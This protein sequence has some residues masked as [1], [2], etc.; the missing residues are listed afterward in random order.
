MQCPICHI[1]GSTQL[2]LNK[3]G[4][5]RYA[6]VKHYSHLDRDSKKP[7]FTYCKITDL[8]ALKTLLSQQNI[9]LKTEAEAPRSNGQQGRFESHDPQLRSLA[10]VHQNNWT[11]SSVRIEHQP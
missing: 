10:S 3:E 11:G 9:S 5:V 4:E 6:R 7:Q 8:E 1:T 2:F